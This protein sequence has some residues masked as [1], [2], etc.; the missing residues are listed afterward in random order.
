MTMIA[1][2]FNLHSFISYNN[3][4]DV[5]KIYQSND[6]KYTQ[7]RYLKNELDKCDEDPEYYAPYRS[8]IL[9]N[10]AKIIGY[11]IPK[12]M[13][14]KTFVITYEDT[15]LQDF[16]VEEFVEGT[17]IQLFYNPKIEK[18]Q[19]PKLEKLIKSNLEKNQGWMIATRSK[20]H[21]TSLFYKN[22]LNASRQ[23]QQDNNEKNDF[24][25]F[26]SMFI[27]CGV[28]SNLDLSKLDKNI[29]YNFVIQH[30]QNIVINNVESS[31]MY[32]I[33]GYDI[34]NNKP[35][36]IS[37]YDLYKREFENTDMKVYIPCKFDTSM[38]FDFEDIEN[39]FKF[40]NFIPQYR[41]YNFEKYNKISPGLII[42]EPN[43]RHTKITNPYYIYLKELRG[44]QPKLE[45]TYYDLRQANRIK[46]FLNHFPEYSDD[47]MLYKEKIENFTR[48]LYDLYVNTKMLKKDVITNVDFQLRN[49]ISNLHKIYLEELRPRN[50]TLQ[51]RGV[52]KYVN[53]L[54]PSILMYSMNYKKRPITNTIQS[55][56]ANIGE[57]DVL[58]STTG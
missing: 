3:K 23:N 12:S 39:M 7:I 43:G 57:N 58:Y 34:V 45:Y 52:A 25:D 40:S 44:N 49:H 35:N 46:E 8:I 2:N 31:K 9:D 22:H 19:N 47:F 32:L 14:Y 54:A 6:D 17:Q 29:C 20:I 4:N 27:E 51:M 56:N 37:G 42:K 48:T 18:L 41:G 38:C 10:D 13:D 30:E 1:N 55:T 15:P 16:T 11:G 26:A 21:A 33:Q 5:V 24:I 36:Y 50:N 53:N 28:D